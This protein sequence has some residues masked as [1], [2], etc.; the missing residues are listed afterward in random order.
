MKDIDGVEVIQEKNVLFP[1][2]FSLM[3]KPDHIEGSC[4][5][6]NERLGQ[7]IWMC[8]STPTLEWETDY[9]FGEFILCESCGS[10]FVIKETEKKENG[11]N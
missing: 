9:A 4:Q 11:I 10:Q 8:H 2:R 3:K 7:L 6:C 1:M 5:K